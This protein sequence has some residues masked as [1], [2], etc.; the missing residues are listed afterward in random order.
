MRM[1]QAVGTRIAHVELN[2]DLIL[3]E[4]FGGKS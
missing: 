4:E 3:V 2:T 1:R